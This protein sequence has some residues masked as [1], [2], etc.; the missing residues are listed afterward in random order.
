M[1]QQKYVGRSG[2]GESWS[3]PHRKLLFILLIIPSIAYFLASA[4]QA[5]VQEQLAASRQQIDN[6]DRQI[7]DLINQRAAVV[8]KIGKIKSSAG[9]PINV[10]HREQEV[11]KHVAALGA[12]G[13]FPASRL[14]AI[15]TTLLAQMRDWEDERHNLR[16]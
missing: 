12:S 9:L 11:L 8:E 13:P 5:S 15:Y 6:I 2:I 10:P 14:Q 16:R 1:Y 4:Q 7:V 3:M